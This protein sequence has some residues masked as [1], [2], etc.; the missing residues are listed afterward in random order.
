MNR[1]TTYN[2]RQKKK[3]NENMYGYSLCPSCISDE[4]T[5]KY[6][7]EESYDYRILFMSNNKDYLRNG[8]KEA[9]YPIFLSS[10]L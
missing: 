4:R 7:P 10:K 6:F 2:G 5:R 3:E 8:R 1:Y 9:I